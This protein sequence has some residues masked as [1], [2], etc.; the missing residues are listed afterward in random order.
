MCEEPGRDHDADQVG[1]GEGDRNA[2]D[3]RDGVR[4]RQ[5]EPRNRI[6]GRTDR[7]RLGERAGN[8]SGGGARVIAE[9]P[10]D[11][12]GD[13]QPRGRDDDRERRLLQPAA[14]EA[15]K[16]LRSGPEANR[17]QEQQKEGLLD[18]SRDAQAQ[19]TDGDAGEQRSGHGAERE[20][21]ELQLAED[22]SDPE[23]EKKRDLGMLSQRADERFGH[24]H[25]LGRCVCRRLRGSEGDH[26]TACDRT[27][28][29]ADVLVDLIVQVRE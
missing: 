20:A 17:E 26:V 15:A 10:A 2:I 11:R 13:D 22:V 1:Y 25:T 28:R 6:A 3:H 23:D 9:Q 4:V 14:P 16:K 27:H 8:E 12:V 18:F 19:L 24:V 7:R 5:T 29:A 21:P